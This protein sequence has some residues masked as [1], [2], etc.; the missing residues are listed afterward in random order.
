MKWN[1]KDYTK[2]FQYVHQ[3]GEDLLD[4]IDE[5]ENMTILDVGC[6][7]GRLTKQLSEKGEVTGIDQSFDMIEEAKKQFPELTFLHQDA[8]FYQMDPVDVIFSNAVFHWIKDQDTLLENLYHNLKPNGQFVVEFGGYGNTKSVY[9]ALKY[10]VEKHGYQYFD[11]FFFPTE[12]QYQA[13]LEKHHFEVENIV[14]FERPTVLKG[15]DGLM[16]FLYMFTSQQLKYVT[17]PKDS[18][19]KEVETLLKPKLYH[20]GIWTLDYVRIRVK[21]RRK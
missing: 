3:Y 10:V 20:D 1:A 7:N 8:C 13:L 4:W 15:E 16:N 5:K 6:G 2:N 11:P 9:D 14:L 12:K 19:Y 21:A 18:I 17:T